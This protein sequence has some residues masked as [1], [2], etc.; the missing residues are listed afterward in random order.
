MMFRSAYDKVRVRVALD[1]GNGPGA[2]QSAKRECD[3]NQI[4]AKYQRTGVVTWLAKR[5]GEFRDVS[6]V[7][8]REALDIV[9]RGREVFDELP[10]TIRERFRND[11]GEFLDFM[12]DGKN[13][14]EA[15]SLGLA[16]PRAE[17]P[18]P[19]K[20]EVVPQPPPAA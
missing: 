1:R 7:D 5:D 13:F 16:K 11:P 4:M 3:I 6:G 2:V 18:A 17:E 8:F 10:S 20:V 14:D 12:A 15:V 9:I 19:I